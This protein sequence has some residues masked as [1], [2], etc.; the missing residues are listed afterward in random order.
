M[1]AR[2]IGSGTISF[3]LISI[4]VRLYPATSSKAIAFH[5]LHAKCGARIRQQ[6]FCPVCNEV[7][8][9]ADLVRGFEFSKD[10]YVRFTE[11]E[12]KALEEQV[13]RVIDLSEFVPL[14]QIDPIYFDRGYYLGPDKGG[15]KAYQLLAEAMEK[16]QRVALAQFVMRGKSNLVLIRSFQGGLMM[17]TMY[18]ADE[19]RDFAEIDRGQS[20]RVREGELELAVRLIDELSSAEFKPEKYRDEYRVKVLDAVNLKVEGKEVTLAAP[21]PQRGQVI[22]LMEA[23]KQS[24]ERRVAASGARAAA[25]GRAGAPERAVASKAQAAARAEEKPLDFA[26]FK[27]VFTGAGLE[28]NERELRRSYAGLTAPVEKNKLSWKEARAKLARLKEDLNHAGAQGQLPQTR[29]KTLKAA[30]VP[31]SARDWERY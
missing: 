31:L 8:E 26:E 27:S 18:Y 23:L 21:E 9:R 6:H 10:Q 28:I 22:D 12:L 20:A 24:L 14:G 29:A 15:E 1:A 7:V 3:G 13:T 2:S 5:Y 17:H 16:T 25:G 11:E 30:R 4:P 19:V